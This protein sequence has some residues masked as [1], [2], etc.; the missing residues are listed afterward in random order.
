MTHRPIGPIYAAIVAICQDIVDES[1]SRNSES[2]S[3]ARSLRLAILLLH[4]I[5]LLFR[6][7]RPTTNRV[8]GM[9]DALPTP[10]RPVHHLARSQ[11]SSVVVL[12]VSILPLFRF[13]GI[14]VLNTFLS[15]C[16]SS[17]LITCPYYQ[18]DILSGSS[19]TGRGSVIL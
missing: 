3:Q 15:V 18:F 7:C 5:P 12:H 11:S 17:L 4:L 1:S 2:A 9:T 8:A 19:Q 10:C 13:P 6:S 14:S 16:F